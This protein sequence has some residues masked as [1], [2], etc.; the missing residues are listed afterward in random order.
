MKSI[1]ILSL[2][3][4]YSSLSQDEYD[5]FIKY[6]E[7][8]VKN[9]EVEDLRVLAFS[10][11]NI[12]DFVNIFNDFYVGYKIQHISKE[13]DLLRFGDNYTINIE[14]KSNSDE[15][16]I[17]K[18]L[19][20][21]RYYLSHINK[22]I[23][24]FSFVSQ[25]N[26]LYMLNSYNKLEE[27]NLNVLVQLLTGQNLSNLDNP[28]KLFNPSDYLVSPFN[29]TNKFINGQ[30]FLT[31][32]QE[33][34]K[35][36]IFK[37]LN[38]G[39]VEY[40]SVSG[41]AGTGKTLL[42]YDIVKSVIKNKKVAIVHCGQLNEGHQRLIRLGWNI[43]SIKSFRN[44]DISDLDLVI[45]DEAQ[46][47][48][49]WQFDKLILDAKA[50]N[51][52]CIFSYDKNQTLSHK[53]S[54]LD[55]ES[56]IKNING[57]KEFKLSNKIRTNKEIA[58]FIKLLFNNNRK[59]DIVNNGNIDFDYF[60]DIKTVK[61]YIELMSNSG[62]EVLKLTPSQYDNEYH[63][64]Y[65]NV[66]SKNSHRVIGQ[67]FDNVAVVIDE[68]FSYHNN[69]RLIYR[70]KTHYDSVKML[71]QNITRTRKKLKLIIISNNEVLNRCLSIFK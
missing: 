8:D 1:N 64:T 3:Q 44:Y 25:T 9:S 62:W 52:H 68:F 54:L 4:A 67:E 41:S 46:R 20:R 57:S 49:E 35:S 33:D 50:K 22:V 11:Y 24:N 39:N 69:G 16:K 15:S 23:H 70:A 6:Y 34:I 45:I 43:I 60:T 38:S 48:Y 18:Q 10:M 71:F 2:V 12:L 63:E 29:S 28:D 36:Q 5:S 21:N 17:E 47:I 55:I 59:I 31:N 19:I 37:K 30:Y 61:N 13:F 53:E 66:F 42:T 56:K 58:N 14:L 32:Q 40:I 7:I 65:S 26:K 27:V 51:V